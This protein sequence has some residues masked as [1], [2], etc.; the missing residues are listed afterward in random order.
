MVNLAEGYGE[1]D[2]KAFAREIQW[3]REGEF[4]LFDRDPDTGLGVPGRFAPGYAESLKNPR[5]GR[6]V[7]PGYRASRRVHSVWFTPGRGL[8]GFMT[9]IFTRLDR[10]PGFLSALIYALERAGKAVLYG[11]RDC[12]DCSLPDCAYLCPM[13]ACS[14]NQR[15][16]PCGGSHEGLCEVETGQKTCIWVR[17][18]ERL[19][20]Y[21]ELE[22]T[23]AGPVIYFDAGLE[24]TSS[25]VNTYLG[26][27][28]SAGPKNAGTGKGE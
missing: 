28:H 14:K 1:N 11:C 26:R 16:G 21:G 2:W 19:K 15:N 5:A 9:R 27:D 20:Y 13:S 7:T 17:A 10:K 18:H 3:S 12:G 23:F 22:K 25:W 8:F 6:H 4:Y 24:G